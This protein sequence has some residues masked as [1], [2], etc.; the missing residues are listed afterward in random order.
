MHLLGFVSA[1]TKPAE[2]KQEDVEQKE[3]EIKDGAGEDPGNA[4]TV[5]GAVIHVP[6]GPGVVCGPAHWK[7]DRPVYL[8]GNYRNYYGAYRYHDAAQVE[9]MEEPRLQALAAHLGAQFL[10]GKD[11]L[12]IGCNAGLVSFVAGQRYGARRVVGVDIDV[13][14]IKAA[15]AQRE[16]MLSDGNRP[17]KDGSFEF[18]AEDFVLAPWPC[19][20]DGGKKERFH[21][22]FVFSVTKWVHFT[23][24]DEGIRCLFKRCIKRLHPGGILVLE[25]QDWESYK[26]KRHLTRDIRDT[27]TGIELRPE[28]F[29]TYLTD[30]GLEPHGEVRAAGQSSKGFRRPICLYRKP[31]SWKSQG[32]SEKEKAAHV[33]TGKKRAASLSAEKP[34]R[35]PD[36]STS[37]IDEGGSVAPTTDGVAPG[38]PPESLA[39]MLRKRVKSA[40]DNR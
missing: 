36:R 29:A 30:L 22:I 18:R 32:V 9:H 21:V 31:E 17:R 19:V 40:L 35:C 1:S 27:V 20:P 4:S 25:A 7:S 14:L 8:Y 15:T 23:H 3:V 26:K 6:V 38:T 11:T 33:G 5:S 39:S 13:G 28:G 37:Q 16:A 34:R 24:G 10:E 2:V 12:D